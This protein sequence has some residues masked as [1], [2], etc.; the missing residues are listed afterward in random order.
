[1]EEGLATIPQRHAGV[2]NPSKGEQQAA[3][4]GQAR[5]DT[6]APAVPLAT[7]NFNG[8]R[9]DQESLVEVTSLLDDPSRY[10]Q[11][12][13]VSNSQTLVGAGAGYRV[14]EGVSASQLAVTIPV[15]EPQEETGYHDAA[16]VEV[17]MVGAPQ[18]EQRDQDIKDEHPN[19]PSVAKES[20]YQHFQLPEEELILL[21]LEEAEEGIRMVGK[22]IARPITSTPISSTTISVSAPGVLEESA[23]LTVEKSSSQNS[24]R[25]LQATQDIP[26][27]MK[28]KFGEDTDNGSKLPARNDARLGLLEGSAQAWLGCC[29]CYEVFPS[30]EALH[31][32]VATI[33][34]QTRTLPCQVGCHITVNFG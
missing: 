4:G 13:I 3:D 26:T 24:D 5:E 18:W 7:P 33:H 20:V 34:Q 21:N 11:G 25:L 19:E 14:G 12:V 29:L 1:M 17:Q 31:L 23:S 15:E 9:L 6:A 27:V 30:R 32:H 28:R 10:S 16:R 22:P 2:A 8:M